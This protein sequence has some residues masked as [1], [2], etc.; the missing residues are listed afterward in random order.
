MSGNPLPPRAQRS[1]ARQR[2]PLTVWLLRLYPCA[3]RDR[4]GTE[5]A[6]LLA[7]ER[8]SLLALLS[9]VGG[10]LDAHRHPQLLAP[11]SRPSAPYRLRTLVI[12]VFCAYVAFV[13]AALAFFEAVN[14]LSF[15]PLMH[16]YPQL[17]VPWTVLAASAAVALSAV[18]IGGLPILVTVLKET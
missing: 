3:W 7:Q 11:A 8:V 4:Y 5:L 1:A 2:Q 10:A 12:T 15:A 6:E 17:T 18:L 16:A 14:D 13:V 9:V